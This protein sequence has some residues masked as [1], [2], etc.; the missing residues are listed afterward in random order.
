MPLPRFKQMCRMMIEEKFDLKWISFFRCSNADD[1]CFDLMKESGCLGVY[2][3]IESGDQRILKLMEKFADVRRYRE[4]IRKLHDR[5]ILTFASFI[6]GYPGETRESVM[7]TLKFVE[8]T[9]P[10]FFNVKL[11]FH[12]PI[13]PIDKRRAE[14]GI[15]GNHYGWRHDTMTW[16]EAADWVEYLLRTV[17]AS[18]PLTLYGF[19]IWSI[20]YLLQK[21]FSID[22][23]LAFG[24]TAR[25]MLVKSLDDVEVEF[26]AEEAEMARI[27]DGW[28][29]WDHRIDSVQ[30]GIP[31]NVIER[32]MLAVS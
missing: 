28:Q 14:F 5:D 27:F 15:Q 2:L 25:E 21:G 3:G 26:Q 32:D 20:P 24:R 31:T 29:P 23:I 30:E 19:S 7:N 4:A 1:E 11:Y 6:V 13:A 9:A 22:Q 17:R 16:Q 10:T 18:I 8:E 12:N